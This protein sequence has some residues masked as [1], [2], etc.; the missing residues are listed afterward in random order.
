MS[1]DRIMRKTGNFLNKNTPAILTGLS[2]AGVI[3]AVGLAIKATPEAHREI[4]D[5]RSELG[6]DLT[7]VDKVRLVWRHYVPT[8]AV[9]VLTVGTIIGAQSISHRRQAMIMS[10]YALTETSFREYQTKVRDELGEK[11]EDEIRDKIAQDHI[12][13][14]PMVNS[15]VIVTGNGDVTCFD[16][17]SGRYFTSSMETIRQSV[18]DINEQCLNQENASQNE[19]YDKIGLSGVKFGEDQ[20]WRVDHLMKLHYTSELHDGK[21]VLVLEYPHLPIPGFYHISR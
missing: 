20:G 18:N 21:P 5:A 10:A 8:G 13:D 4:Q 14:V 19:F 9:V 2:V 1:F 15:Q 12:M 3:S 17:L 7:P 6:E 16:S 11:K